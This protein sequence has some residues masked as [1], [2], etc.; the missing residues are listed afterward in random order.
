MMPEEFFKKNMEMWEK[1]STSYM[2]N[3]FKMVEKTMEQSQV[4]KDRVDQAV[5]E[6]VSQQLD[7]TLAGLKALQKQVETL[8]EKV[9]QLAEKE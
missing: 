8:S 7:A 2:D 6:A 9:D 4:F 1:F 5:T 3:M